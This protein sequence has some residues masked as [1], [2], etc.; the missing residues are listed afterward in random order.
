VGAYAA[1]RETSLFAIQRVE[2]E[3]ASPELAGRIRAKLAP[4]VG[5]SLVAFDRRAGDRRLV[6]LPEVAS[7]S[8][9]R[10]FPHSLRVTVETERPAA[11]L[12]QGRDA[13]LVSRSVR[14]LETLS[15]P[16]PRLP[17]IW[18]PRTADVVVGAT[19][20]GNP[21][22]AVGALGSIRRARLGVAVR[23]VRAADGEL[24]LVLAG[25]ARVLLGDRAN[26]PLKLAVL[27]RILR[28]TDGAAYIDLSVPERAVA[29][30]TV[31]YSP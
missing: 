5:T 3:G 15:R 14:V 10:D 4:L 23:T 27:R 6:E 9:D 8:Y 24:S 16:Y 7:A 31:S 29:G 25:G 22:A 30:D 26:L 18:L 17:R 28:L 13:W 12:R 21:A 2:V 11:V 20:D 1:A 19:L